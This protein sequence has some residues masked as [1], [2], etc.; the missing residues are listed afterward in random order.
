MLTRDK[1]LEILQVVNF[2]NKN[3]DEVTKALLKTNI[4]E[5]E[6]IEDVHHL[7][8]FGRLPVKRKRGK[9]ILN[10]HVGIVNRLKASVGS[11]NYVVYDVDSNNFDKGLT[12]ILIYML[13]KQSIIFNS[14]E[15]EDTISRQQALKLLMQSL[16]EVMFKDTRG[17]WNPH[18][19]PRGI[20]C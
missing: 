7:N 4:F 10:N 3:I 13:N 8:C 12:D 14:Q 19:K 6:D 17:Q 9:L 2:K 5:F 18:R 11:Y 16:L 15:S 20:A 1:T